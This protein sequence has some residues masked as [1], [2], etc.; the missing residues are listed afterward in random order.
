MY[1][2]IK[3][4]GK[5]QKV[6][7]G[8]EIQVELIEGG[9]GDKVTF[10]PVLVVDDGGTAHVGSALAGSSVRGTIAGEAK[11]PKVRVFHYKPKTGYRKTTGHRQRYTVVTIDDVGFKGGAKAS[12]PAAAKT[13]KA[14][15]ETAPKPD[16]AEADAE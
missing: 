6:Q 14:K 10:E 12:K 15:A 9:P 4:G 13:T 1:A 8:D 16:T 7:A 2:V 11:G 5:Q 3:A